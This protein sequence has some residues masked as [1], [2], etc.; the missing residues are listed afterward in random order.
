MEEK[1]FLYDT[2]HCSACKGCQV[3]CKVWNDLPSSLE[4]DHNEFSGSYQNP[5]DI[6]EDTRMIITFSEHEPIENSTKRI[7]W[8]FNRRSC[9]HCTDAGCVRVC[10]TGTLSKNEE[11]GMVEIN[12][13]K[14]IEC[15]YCETACPFDV[16]R[17]DKD[18]RIEKC[19]G[20]ASRVANGMQ[21]ACV[22]TCPAGALHFGD[23]DEMIKMACER[24]EALKARGYSEA[25]VYGEH[26][27]GGLHV[28][29]VLKYGPEKHGEP[30]DP[31]M[32]VI[33]RFSEIVRPV[34][35]V[36]VGATVAGLAFSFINGIGYHRDE[37]RYDEKTGDKFDVDTG[38]LLAHTDLDTHETTHYEGDEAGM[39][40]GSKT[41][42]FSDKKGGE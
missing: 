25:C 41:I 16:P 32:P 9:K 8:A 7:G 21:P 33:T 24:V 11:T 23:R 35:A 34:A 38:D 29:S 39:H 17:Y 1:A 12:K 4:L 15:H 19:D 2:S 26:E 3:A 36:G 40:F 20:C 22:S 37:M 42:H 30:V 18:H 6:N 28:I 13:D 27:M 14:C 5:V 31:Q 10:P